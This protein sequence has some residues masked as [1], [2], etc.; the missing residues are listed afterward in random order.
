MDKYI[1]VMAVL[2]TAWAVTACAY[3]ISKPYEYDFI[4]EAD[5]SSP[6]QGTGSMLPTI[7][8]TSILYLK[9]V[10]SIEDININDIIYFNRAD[11]NVIHR[12]VY[13]INDGCITKGDNNYIADKDVVNIKDIKYK[14]IAIKYE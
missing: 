4:V 3:P 11:I 2:I 10:N 8:P 9:N 5:T 6:V 1:A 14:V 13:K 7:T 12:C